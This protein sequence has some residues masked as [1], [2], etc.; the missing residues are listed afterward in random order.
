[1][2]RKQILNELNKLADKDWAEDP[3]HIKIINTQNRILGV[4]TNDLKEYAKKLAKDDIESTI[5]A[6]KDDSFEETLL[7]GLI[8]GKIA[9]IDECYAKI[10]EFLPKIDNWATCDQTVSALKVFKKDKD[11]KYFKSFVE[12]AKD[13]R[14]YY[15]RFGIIML[16]TYYLKPET[17][18]E[19]LKLMS[20][21]NNNAYYVQMAEAWL[22]SVSFVKYREQTLELIK[23]KTLPQ[24][25]QNKAICKCRDSFRVSSFDKEELKKYRI[26]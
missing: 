20:Q 13:K 25:V 18:G 2:E 17:I 5:L 4:R 12:L 22:I 23:T 9:K 21:I 6:L 10:I 19:V 15:A 24:F 1:M 26:K 16:M 7:Q 3:K 8:I 11:N 14:E